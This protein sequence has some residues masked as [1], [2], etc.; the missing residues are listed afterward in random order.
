MR[1][2][3][4]P[5]TQS[6]SRL[7]HSRKRPASVLASALLLA[8]GIL[9]PLAL[10]G[11]I[12]AEDASG[13]TDA[14]A[15]PL[16][17]YVGTYTGEKSK[18]IYFFRFDPATGKATTPELAGETES[19][20]FLAIHP[21]KRFLYSVNEVSPRG[22]VSA[23]AI[24]LGSG[25]L[26]FLNTESSEGGSPCHLVVDNAGKHLLVAN[27][28]GGNAAVL[29]IRA[30][31]KLG[32]SMSRVDKGSIRIDPELRKEPPRA[33]SIHL[34]AAN[35]FAVVA[36]LG[37][38]RLMVYRFAAERGTLSPVSGQEEGVV[39]KRGAGPRHFTFHPSGRFAYVINESDC[40]MTALSYEAEKGLLKEIA[41]V[42][43][44]PDKIVKGY[45]TAEVVAHPSG[46]FLY[47]SNRGHDSIAVFAIDQETGALKPVEHEPTQGKTPRNFAVDPTGNW[48]FAANQNSS[49][50]VVFKIDRETGSLEPTGEVIEAPSPVCIRFITEEG[51]ASGR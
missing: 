36:Y 30:D 19:P 42:S 34:D 20:S 8:A 14:A 35:R 45:S 11:R 9:S 37:F 48:L 10:P 5:S 12:A 4:N 3:R 33:H 28:G 39:L 31:G 1:H 38:D 29:L 23:F 6:A 32:S 49:T 17:V 22:R 25:K 43:T 15:A 26:T 27:Y 13:K 51:P 2:D 16:R 24:N 44:L 18:G 46:K 7:P 47:G 40:T 50:I 21:S 41:T